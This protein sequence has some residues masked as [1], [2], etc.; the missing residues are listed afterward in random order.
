MWHFFSGEH[1]FGQTRCSRIHRQMS[2][3]ARF[4][5]FWNI[6]TSFVRGRTSGLGFI[7]A[8]Q[9]KVWSQTCL[10]IWIL[11]MLNSVP[12]C[13]TAL[14]CSSE[15]VTNAGKWQQMRI[16]MQGHKI[17]VTLFVLFGIPNGN[18]GYGDTRRVPIHEAV[19]SGRRW[20]LEY[21]K[22]V[23]EKESTCAIFSHLHLC[24]T[25]KNKDSSKTKFLTGFFAWIVRW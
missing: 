21:W 6:K 22:L 9:W 23:K 25:T 15:T 13:R 5:H 11:L 16:F 4:V 2:Q 19:I 24:W 17:S 7:M 12:W 1:Y 14:L 18:D 8:C 20:N 10:I 3:K